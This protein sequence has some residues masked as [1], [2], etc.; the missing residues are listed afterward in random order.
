M[1]D[2]SRPIGSVQKDADSHGNRRAGNDTLG[3]DP[4][5]LRRSVPGKYAR[6][7]IICVAVAEPISLTRVSSRRESPVSPRLTRRDTCTQVARAHNANTR[8]L[9]KR[10]TECVHA[11]FTQQRADTRGGYVSRPFV[12][13]SNAPRRDTHFGIF[14]ADNAVIRATSAF[15][16]SSRE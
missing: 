3:R 15:H 5:P 2:A 8:T 14:A 11:R 1:R 6:I 13:Y 9:Y 16:V 10:A 4:V 12:E 7:P